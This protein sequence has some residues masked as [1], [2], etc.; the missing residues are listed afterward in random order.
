[1]RK[2]TC[3]VVLVMCFALTIFTPAKGSAIADLKLGTTTPPPMYEEFLVN[4]FTS[5]NQQRPSI[6][7]EGNGD[8]VITWPS[9]GQR[10]TKWDIYA[11]R[12]TK[13]GTRVGDEFL[14]NY[15]DVL[16][17]GPSAAMAS[18]GDFVITWHSSGQDGSAWG[19]YA[20]RFDSNGFMVGP[21]FR[22]N[23][24]TSGVQGEPSAAMNTNGDFL[25][26]WDS[27]QDGSGYGIYAQRYTKDG[28]KDG[29][30]FRVNTYTSDD[31]VE[32]SVAMGGD[33]NFI[34]TWCSYGQ[35]GSSWGVY[36]QRFD[37][38]GNPLGDEFRIN[39]YT[40]SAQIYP[41]NAMDSAGN[42][43]ITWQSWN[44]DGPLW[45]VRG[46]RFKD[47]I[48]VGNEFLVKIDT[49]MNQP[50]SMVAIDG[51][52][53]FVVT[54][55]G[56]DA[57]GWGIFAKKY[58]SDGSQ[59]G[60]EFQLNAF[61]NNDQLDPAV[62]MNGSGDCVFAWQSLNQFSSSSG[63]DV[64]ARIYQG[65]PPTPT[66][67][68]TATP[69][70]TRTPTFTPVITKTPTLT[71]SSTSTPS[72]ITITL[73]PV[74]QT[75]VESANP[76]A[77]NNSVDVTLT[78]VYTANP[79]GR[80]VTQT[81]VKFDLSSLPRNAVIQSAEL[82]LYQEGY[83]TVTGSTNND[84]ASI[85]AVQVTSDW[86]AS[87]VMWRTKPSDNS[88][89]N[90]YVVVY[91]A[92]VPKWWQGWKITSWVQAWVS[93]ATPNYGILLK[94]QNEDAMTI[95]I[96]FSK[97]GLNKPKLTITYEQGPPP[98]KNP[99]LSDGKVEPP[100]GNTTT[101]FKF[102]VYYQD[103]SG[104][105]VVKRLYYDG[106]VNY[107]H[108]VLI[109]G[110]ANNGVYGATLTLPIG[111]HKFGFYFQDNDGYVAR[112]PATGY[113]DGPTV[114]A[115]N[116]RSVILLDSNNYSKGDYDN[117]FYWVALKS[118]IDSPDPGKLY[119]NINI[120]ISLSNKLEDLLKVPSDIR[121]NATSVLIIQY[122]PKTVAIPLSIPEGGITTAYWIGYVDT[123]DK[124]GTFTLSIPEGMRYY[125]TKIVGEIEKDG[126]I[127]DF[128]QSIY[129]RG[130]QQVGAYSL[131]YA[132]KEFLKK[133]SWVLNILDFL[134]ELSDSFD[135][136]EQRRAERIEP[137]LLVNTDSHDQ[138]NFL[139]FG[140]LAGEVRV[141]VPLKVSLDEA[142]AALSS[143]DGEFAFYTRYMINS[144]RTN[145]YP[146]GKKE[147]SRYEVEF[148]ADKII[149]NR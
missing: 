32:S 47:G 78:G 52:G 105:P 128:G 29:T 98:D 19:V 74:A 134:E 91:N 116:S 72:V 22:V 107:I 53:N 44:Q 77:N 49:Y 125:S 99:V 33:G 3:F 130:L 79:N 87:S 7:M 4:T 96:M 66:A 36:A 131:N 54:Y 114:T 126:G 135:A 100:T 70:V 60:D 145:P 9:H 23:S 115:D 73:N 137:S 39:S 27:E 90:H 88:D 83:S 138:I 61:T 121:S 149:V 82:T 127:S 84:V 55:E 48:K 95:A 68:R 8:F 124:K 118:S 15:S 40:N 16:C 56:Q 1:M 97:G 106:A 42:F 80:N 17:G 86:Q 71:P 35:D 139:L 34:V 75:Y 25:I 81:L 129:Y 111:T 123:T 62:K 28:T 76:D 11:Q 5:D 104:V 14:V 141:Y 117:N 133:A 132:A 12:F 93:G 94:G 85:G 37:Q 21:E 65:N 103:D 59:D 136:N 142:I 10:G 41:C 108:M 89:K 24:T 144:E 109:S 101:Q 13:N 38:D 92:K 120:K 67:T 26:T 6:A 110:S 58:K 69:T 140:E 112:Y 46:Q 113:I 18:N 2:A 30:E 119:R 64:Y 143:P 51:N 57:S 20:Q 102:S 50:D 148:F 122:Q 43:V 147:S 63:D 146:P 31:Q 45:S